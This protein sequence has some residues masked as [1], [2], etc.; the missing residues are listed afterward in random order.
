VMAITEGKHGRMSSHAYIL[1]ILFG[2]TWL[3]LLSWRLRA[4]LVW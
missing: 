2:T 4:S 1:L 3:I